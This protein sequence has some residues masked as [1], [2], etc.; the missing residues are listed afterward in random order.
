MNELFSRFQNSDFGNTSAR[1]EGA[2]DFVAWSELKR[3]AGA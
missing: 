2:S 1:F 3:L